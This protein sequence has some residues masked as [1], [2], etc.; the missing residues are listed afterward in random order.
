MILG[1]KRG[2]KR[3]PE[4]YFT[5]T[6]DE[7][8]DFT[9]EEKEEKISKLEIDVDSVVDFKKLL[10]KKIENIYKKYAFYNALPSYIQK[11]NYDFITFWNKKYIKVINY[12]NEKS[13]FIPYEY[14]SM[15][16]EEYSNEILSEVN[17][18]KD[19]I[20]ELKN[21]FEKIR[22]EIEILESHGLNETW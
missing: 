14:L 17:K 21:N 4:T 8:A 18:R 19:R 6:F 22:K 7:P 5:L 13:Y 2:I 12:N 16:E 3:I 11:G 1:L 10:D 9:I 20:L 15:S